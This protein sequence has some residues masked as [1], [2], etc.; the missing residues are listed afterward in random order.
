M[1]TNPS[2][3]LPVFLLSFLPLS[4][5]LLLPLIL[6][7]FYSFLK[8][9]L[10]AYNRLHTL[11]ETGDTAEDKVNM[12]LILN[13]H[14]LMILAGGGTNR[15]LTNKQTQVISGYE[16]CY[17]KSNRGGVRWGGDQGALVRAFK[18]GFLKGINLRSESKKG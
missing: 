18:E 4:L 9:A 8:Y 13:T 1:H 10:N 2:Q 7:F 15:Q 17:E 6:F 16:K 3:S 11:I 5:P 14:I 12:L